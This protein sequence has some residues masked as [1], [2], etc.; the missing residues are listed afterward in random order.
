MAT[1]SQRSHN[2]LALGEVLFDALP[3]G[4]FIGGAPANCAAHLASLGVAAFLA[5]RVGADDLGDEAL[6][7][8]S[9]KGVDV[10]LC[11]R[12]AAHPTGFVRV[13]LN[14][15]GEASYDIRPAAWDTLT[16]SPALREAASSCDALVFGSLAQRSP[17]SQLAVLELASLSPRPVFDV[18]LRPGST[19][20]TVLGSIEGRQLWLLKVNEHEAPTL[21]SWLQPNL[22]EDAVKALSYPTMAQ[23]LAALCSSYAVVTLGAHGAVLSPPGG[24]HVFTSPGFSVAVKDTV[25]SGDAF[26]ASL[27]SSL[28]RG[29]GEEQALRRACAV[30]A[31]VASKDGAMPPLDGEA[32]E[33]MLRGSS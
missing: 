8:L 12:D 15:R 21:L 26:L 20:E 33:A 13:T 5:S 2:V 29:E 30:G 22:T 28:L 14:A 32:I 23:R 11:S 27:L 16:A 31:F 9:E 10:S 4:L 25:G 6:L 17:D 18:N 1:P 3:S 19:R 24:E 7:R